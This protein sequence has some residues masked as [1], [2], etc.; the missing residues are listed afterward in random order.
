M[1]ASTTRKR[2]SSAG[3]TLL[4]LAVVLFIVSMLFGVFATTGVGFL[5]GKSISADRLKL[6]AVETALAGFVSVNGRLPCP[7]D[8][9][10]PSTDSNAGAEVR[11]ATGDCT[12]GSATTA[13]QRTGVVPW[14]TLANLRGR[15]YRQFPEPYYLPGSLWSNSKFGNGFHRLRPRSNWN[16]S[17]HERDVIFVVQWIM[18]LG[19]PDHLRQ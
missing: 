13:D 19:M 3:F 1:T 8:G 15:C 4:E 7:A 9:S 11:D 14:K 17:R 2:T 12:T 10:L 16:N 6:R 18:P 5:Q